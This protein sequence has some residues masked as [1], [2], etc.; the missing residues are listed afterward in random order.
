MSRSSVYETIE[1]E[2]F[3]FSNSPARNPTVPSAPASLSRTVSLPRACDLVYIVDS[4][5][6]SLMLSS[7]EWD[8]ERGITNLRLYFVFRE[9]VD[10]AVAES[11][12]VW[13]DTPFSTFAVQG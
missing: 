10:H 5:G 2:P 11:K 1:E 4:D 3:V 13:P 12:R 8:D 9:K 7:E 6:H